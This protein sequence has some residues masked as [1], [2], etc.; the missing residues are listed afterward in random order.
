MILMIDNYD[1]F[2]FNLVRYGR[3]LG[4]EMCVRRNDEITLKDIETIAPSHIMISPGPCSPLEAGISLK[5]I[6]HFAGKIPI[7]GICLGHQSIGQVFG[8]QV[9]RADKPIHGKVMPIRH[10]ASGL[11]QG[12]PSPMQVTRYH[13]LIVA[14]DLLPDDL[15][16]TAE[17]ETGEIMALAHRHLPVVGVQFHPEAVLSEH[18]HAIIRNFLEGRYR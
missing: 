2:V 5:V 10:N 1:S 3:E 6:Q 18:G 12:L 8:G 9:V 7:F 4:A 16:I 15:I 11:F 14:R 17:S 13:S